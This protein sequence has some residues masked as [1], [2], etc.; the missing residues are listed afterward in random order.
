MIRH[1]VKF[2]IGAVLLGGLLAVLD[3]SQ[4]LLIVGMIAYTVAFRPAS[5][6]REVL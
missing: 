6:K 1:F 3:A 4:A 5:Y 2:W